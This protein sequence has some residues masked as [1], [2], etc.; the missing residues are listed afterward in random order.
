MS[1]EI[2]NLKRQLDSSKESHRTDLFLIYLV[3]GEILFGVLI[4]FDNWV[5][6]FG[7]WVIV[8]ISW[9]LSTIS[10]K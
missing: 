2:E 8:F 5:F 10:V 1:D 3:V 7:S 4:G 9:K 6:F